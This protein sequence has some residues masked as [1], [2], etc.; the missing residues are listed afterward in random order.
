LLVAESEGGEIRREID[1]GYLVVLPVF[2][3]ER[4]PLNDTAPS[5]MLAILG[6]REKIKPSRSI[7]AGCCRGDIEASGRNRG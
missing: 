5:N 1:R 7:A 6:R 3:I 4:I 2:Q